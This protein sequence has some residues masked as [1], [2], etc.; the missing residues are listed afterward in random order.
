MHRRGRWSR[1]KEG[2]WAPSTPGQVL[3]RYE[4]ARGECTGGSLELSMRR[5]I[6]TSGQA[7]VCGRANHQ[8]RQIAKIAKSPKSILAQLK[9][10]FWL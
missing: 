10:A 6:W 5:L 2:G 9:L 1:A 3:R 8:N 7:E 4:A